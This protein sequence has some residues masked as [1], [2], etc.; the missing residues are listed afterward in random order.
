MPPPETITL[1]LTPD[2]ALQPDSHI[3]TALPT[4]RA[5]HQLIRRS[6]DARGKKVV[7]QLTVAALTSPPPSRSEAPP[8][9][10]STAGPGTPVL[11]VG[12]GPAGLGA[13]FALQQRG[14]HPIVLDRGAPFPTRH[15][16]ARALRLNGVLET[17]SAPYT[18]GLGG[19]GAYSD[20]KLYTR[21]GGAN[22]AR[23][24]RL[25]AWFAG[26]EHLLVEAQPHVGS[27]RLPQ[28]VERMRS[29]L[30]ERG[31]R[32]LFA[33]EATGLLVRDGRVTGL[34]LAD[35]EEME[36]AAVVL[37]PGNSSRGLL[38][39]LHR[40][41]VAMEAKSF[42]V[43]MR[44]EHPRSLI[45]DI[46]HGE[47]AGHPALGA[48]RYSFAFSR[49]PR[50]VYTFCMCPGGHLLPTPPERQHLAV[51]GMSFASRSSKFSNAAIVAAVSPEDWPEESGSPL[52]GIAFQRLIEARCFNEGGGGYLA[53]AQRLTDFMAGRKGDLPECTYRPGVAP[54]ELGRLLPAPVVEALRE[55]LRRAG[56]RMPGYLTGEAIVVAPETLTSSPCRILR[57]ENLESP[58]HTGLFPCG[59]GSGWAGGIT[60][61]FA[62]G[63]AAGDAVLGHA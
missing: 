2:Q 5:Y 30:E 37:A 23:A 55:G 26:D 57:N 33:R 32:F 40:Q 35:G 34:Q 53:P 60:S 8:E 10:E 13:A 9:L 28:L 58:S 12:S 45:D 61:S 18:C 44:V 51:N 19:A 63:L 54:A 59:E 50:P 48:A 31:A 43:G 24:M 56:Q 52:N 21:R 38:A 49:L 17:D 47:Y 46:Q 4:G 15:R 6:I 62:D 16:E 3:R 22:V 20:G 14:L 11:V 42:A 1:R 39:T 36:A 29:H 25:M 41:G 7:V 27:N